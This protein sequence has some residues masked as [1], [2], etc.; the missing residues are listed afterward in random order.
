MITSCCPAWI[1]FAEEFLPELLPNI[2]TCKSPQQMMGAVIKSYFAEKENVQPENIISVSIMPCT[3][4]KFEAQ[5]EHMEQKGVFD[6][7]MV[8]STRELIELIHIYGIDMKNISPEITD[9]PMGV[10]SSAGKIFGAS[11]GVMEAA[12]RTAYKALSGKEMIEFKVKAIRGFKGRKETHLKINDL[13]IGVT[14]VSGLNNA[15]TLMN[16]ITHGRNDLHFIEVM[17]CPGGC[18]AGG[19]QRIGVNESVVEARMEA[20]YEIDDQETLKTSHKNPEVIEL[21]DKFLGEPLG[22]KSHELLHTKYQKR[23]VLL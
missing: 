5:R 2:S 7:D 3:A 22:H 16:E 15:K 20:L 4:K 11:G 9:S 13:Q 10:R 21:Y 17:A 6:V 1:K 12:I 19:G 14:A 23:D 8:I 18:I